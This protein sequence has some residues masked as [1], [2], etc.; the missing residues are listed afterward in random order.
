MQIENAK[1]LV[2]GGSAGIGLAT[3]RMLKGKGAQ[4]AICGRDR[5]KLERAAGE[6]GV[7]A[8]PADVSSEA[9]VARMVRTVI[10]TF[11]DYNVLVNNAG[12]GHRSALVDTRLDDLQR[13]FATNVFGA[14]L[15]ARESARHF[16]E[17][18]YGNIVNVSSSA[19]KRGFANG[20]VYVASKFALSGLTEC[21]RAELRPFNVRVMQVNPS[22]V[23][24]DF[25]TAYSG[26]TRPKSARK[27]IADDIAQA[28]VSMLEQHDRGFVTET[29]VWATNP[30]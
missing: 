20:S 1:A 12:F 7:L 8:V 17:R 10:D 4:V 14:L 27:L 2:T 3:A 15:V 21:W 26:A 9:D 29:S 19:G 13:I 28:I 6:I 5:D 18:Q 11:G 24:T 23:Q 22:E 16:V 25:F 30:D